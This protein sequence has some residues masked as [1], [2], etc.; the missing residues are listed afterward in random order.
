ML[1]IFNVYFEV[2]VTVLINKTKTKPDLNPS[3]LP[4]YKQCLGKCGRIQDRYVKERYS[5]KAL[6]IVLVFLI[7]ISNL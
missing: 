4:K 5:G 3:A 2:H 6:F 7:A 1:N